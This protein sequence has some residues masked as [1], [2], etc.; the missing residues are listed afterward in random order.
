MDS[1]DSAGAGRNHFLHL[2]WIEIMRP[3]V[4]VTEHRANLL[5]LQSMC[6]CN[7]RKRRDNH[8]SRQAERPN[9]NLQRYRRVTHRD[10][11]SDAD[12]CRYFGFEFLDIRTVVG[13]PNTVEHVID[14][15]QQMVAIADIW[16]TDVHF[17]DKCRRFA[18][19]R[20]IRKI[21]THCIAP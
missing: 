19:D 1:N 9:R 11:V 18:E 21:A 2:A 20:Q 7:E 4:D 8:F 12:E 14:T 6:G 16:P 13:E 5:P 10:A 17:V 3:L 15:C